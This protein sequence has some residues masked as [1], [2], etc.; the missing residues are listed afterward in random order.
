MISE[1]VGPEGVIGERESFG[2]PEGRC[3]ADCVFFD[4]VSLM[5]LLKLT[6]PLS[7]NWSV[8]SPA[9]IGQDAHSVKQYD[10]GARNFLFINVP[11]VQRSPLVCSNTVDD[12]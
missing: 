9:I 7:T 4:P 12:W 6:L 3:M 10:A 11:P 1:V 8:P 2:F 5:Y